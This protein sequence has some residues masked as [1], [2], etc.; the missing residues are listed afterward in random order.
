MD[1]FRLPRSIA[2]IVSKNQY[3]LA[4]EEVDALRELFGQ[5]VNPQTQ[6]QLRD[7]DVGL[8]RFNQ[9]YARARTEDKIIDLTIALESSLLSDQRDE[10]RYR[11]ATRGAALL[12]KRRNPK[13]TYSVLRALYDARS[14]IVHGG[15]TLAEIA[16]NGKIKGILINELLPKAEQIVR[17]V[18][19]E[20]LAR[21]NP[22]SS[23]KMINENLDQTVVNSL[24]G[25]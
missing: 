14:E 21:I 16:K 15:R 6:S 7:L 17:E 2:S 25:P 1:D 24:A 18:F 23:L 22:Q 5:L 3:R 12:S 9:A 10:L 20:Y 4:R 13:D 19:I 8:R 11:L